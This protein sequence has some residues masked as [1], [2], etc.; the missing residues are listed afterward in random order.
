MLCVSTALGAV[1][2]LVE[3]LVGRRDGLLAMAA[4]RLCTHE[5]SPR[6]EVFWLPMSGSLYAGTGA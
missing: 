1:R 2:V 4:R 3:Y 5:S 6:V